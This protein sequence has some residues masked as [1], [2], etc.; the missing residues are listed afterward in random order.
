[1]NIF[2]L[3]DTPI[4]CAQALCDKHVVKMILETAQLLCSVH[5]FLGNNDKIPYKAI[6]I[7]HPCAKW[8]RKSQENYLWTCELGMRIADE[9]TRRFGR[10][11]KSQEVIEWALN[12]VPKLP[13]KG[14]TQQPLCMPNECKFKSVVYSYKQYYKKKRDEGMTMKYTKTAPPNWLFNGGHNENII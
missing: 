2:V 3:D 10:L 11:H 5:H 9:Y 6:H 13:S 1:M 12:N 8:V 14:I 7:N 4:G